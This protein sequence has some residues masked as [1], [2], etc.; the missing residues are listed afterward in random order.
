MP[1]GYELLHSGRKCVVVMKSGVRKEIMK[2]AREK[3]AGLQDIIEHYCDGGPENLPRGKYNGNEGW[4]PSAKDKRIRLEALKPR[5]LRAYGFCQQFNGR[6]T[7]FITGVDISKKQDG[8][9]QTILQN[10]GKEA[11][12][13]YGLLKV[14]E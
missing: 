10:S 11:V 5:Q 8:A 14:G 7:L 6:Q 4:F 1:D 3:Q 9:D 12:R 13:I 2:K